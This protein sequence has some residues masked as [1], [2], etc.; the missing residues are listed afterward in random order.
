M[1]RPT[2]TDLDKAAHARAL[3]ERSAWGLLL[4]FAHRWQA[5]EPSDYQA[6]YYTGLG[7]SGLNQFALAETAYR[8]ALALDASDFRVWN[9][10][11]GILFD[12]MNR[13]AEAIAC[14]EKAL[15]IDPQN[16][17]GWSNLANLAGRL[18]RHDQSLECAQRALELDPQMVEAQLHR[19][20]AAQALGKTEILRAA[21]ETL[22]TLP[23]ERFRR[24][25]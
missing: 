7:Y 6:L 17:L 2:V 15:A 20:R 3:C 5:E 19:A 22:A 25:H 18:G 12:V 23:A 21:N 1:N 4:E 24:V 16:R 10:L 11:A 14:L 8:R 9:N 13:P